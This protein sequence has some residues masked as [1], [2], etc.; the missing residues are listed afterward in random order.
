[1]SHEL[2]WDSEMVLCPEC[3]EA[4]GDLW[5]HDFGSLEEIITACG[6]CGEDYV[7]HLRVTHK[8]AA[9]PST[10]EDKP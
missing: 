10:T 1:M 4:Q 7:L 8:Y 3:G 2:D 5:E 9:S 6:S